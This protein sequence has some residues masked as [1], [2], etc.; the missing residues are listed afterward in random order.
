MKKILEILCLIA[1]LSIP[2]FAEEKKD[3]LLFP[4]LEAGVFYSIPQGITKAGASSKILHYKI[5]DFRI[6]YIEED[7]LLGAVSIEMSALARE[8]NISW[9]ELIE[10]SALGF[11]WNSP[12]EYGWMATLINIEFE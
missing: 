10:A 11:W 7:K 9:E 1:I 3:G 6:G 12:D 4:N 5:V 2:L 8:V